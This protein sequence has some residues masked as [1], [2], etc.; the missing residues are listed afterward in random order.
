MAASRGTGR[1]STGDGRPLRLTG[2]A[3]LAAMLGLCL[4][5]AAVLAGAAWLVLGLSLPA[6]VIAVLVIGI[7]TWLPMAVGSRSL[8]GQNSTG[9]SG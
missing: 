4:V 1:A 9:E 3:G 5:G 6:F 7:G 8:T 2:P